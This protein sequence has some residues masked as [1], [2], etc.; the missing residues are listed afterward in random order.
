MRQ[1]KTRA[2]LEY[3]H[4]QILSIVSLAQLKR[5]FER[6]GNFDLRRLL[7]GENPTLRVPDDMS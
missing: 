4:L 2:H 6:R 5:L 3:L 7:D 1:A